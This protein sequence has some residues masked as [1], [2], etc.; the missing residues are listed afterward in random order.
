MRDQD[1]Y[2]PREE[3]ESGDQIRFRCTRYKML[4]AIQGLSDDAPVYINGQTLRV[5][6]YRFMLDRMQ[7]PTT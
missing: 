1:T 3:R 5:K 2:S 4:D 6:D 7:R